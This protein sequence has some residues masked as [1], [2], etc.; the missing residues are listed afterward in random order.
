MKRTQQGEEATTPGPEDVG[1]GRVSDL[2]WE[3]S[4]LDL[5]WPHTNTVRQ[6]L[7]SPRPRRRTQNLTLFFLTFTI[8]VFLTSILEA[9]GETPQIKSADILLSSQADHMQ[10][11]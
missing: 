3:T 8:T 9:Y 4:S 6:L 2:C 1:P 10:T 7:F 11:C 5:P